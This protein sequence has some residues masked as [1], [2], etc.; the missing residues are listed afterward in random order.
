MTFAREDC[1]GIF[2]PHSDPL[3]MVADIAEQPVYIV[4]IDTRAE[5]NVIYKRAVGTEWMLEFDN[6]HSLFLRRV[7]EI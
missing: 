1:K 3:D 4:V 5:V 2:F 7:N 6:S